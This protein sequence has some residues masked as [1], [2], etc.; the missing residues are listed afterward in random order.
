MSRDNYESLN[1][2][3]KKS[4]RIDFIVI[5]SVFVL[6]YLFMSF[7]TQS[8]AKN[9]E[10]ENVKNQLISEISSWSMNKDLNLLKNNEIQVQDAKRN[11][12]TKINSEKEI[13]RIVVTQNNWQKFKVIFD[14]TEY[15]LD[16]FIVHYK[17]RNYKRIKFYSTWNQFVLNWFEKRPSWNTKINDNVFEWNI[18]FNE[19]GDIINETTVEEYMRG[20]AE[21]PESSHNEKRKAL[22]VSIRSYIEYYTNWK[23]ELKFPNEE[24]NA[25]DDPK[26]FQKYLGYN[27]SL[28]AKKWI[29][30]LEDT[31]WEI[32]YYKDEVL[33]VPYYSCTLSKNKRTLNPDEANWWGYFLERKNVFQSKP[34]LEWVD[35]KRDTR[36]KCGHGVWMS[37]QWSEIRAQRWMNYK[38]ILNYY[39]TDIEIK[40]S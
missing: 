13:D 3:K 22:A 9:K 1:E 8:N 18:I 6:T 34:D 40:K 31:K 7:I 25:S 15:F 32:I 39:F 33:R 5:M 10:L 35:P 27:Y 38:E 26:I 23:W 30:A 2:Y 29:Q 17:D 36:E 24:Y 19:K 12:R 4:K 16:K 37:G 28:R 14:D 20:M 21:V 11:V